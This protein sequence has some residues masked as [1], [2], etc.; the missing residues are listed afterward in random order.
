MLYRKLGD[1]GLDVSALGLGCNNF[2]VRIDETDSFKVIEQALEVGVNLFDTA[3]SYGT[4]RSEEILGKAMKGRRSQFILGTKFFFGE[5]STTLNPLWP[6]QERPNGAGGSRRHIF[7]A[8]EESLRRLGTDYIDL[9]MMHRPDPSTPIEE[10]LRALDDAV[11]QGKVR[12]IGCCAFEAW[13]LLEAIWT[14]KAMNLQQFVSAQNYYNVLRREVETEL[15]PAC[16]ATGVSLVPYFPLESGVLTGKYRLGERPPEGTRMTTAHYANRHMTEANLKKVAALQEWAQ[17]RNRS[18]G[19]LA[20]AYVLANPAVDTVISGAT[21]P[22]QV[23]E[24]VKGTA[25]Q[26]SAADLKEIDRLV[27]DNS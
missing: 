22:E 24:N 27:T 12:Y 5:G 23:V 9:Y 15:T 4:G 10:T 14:A 1:S 7:E 25:W 13:R 11:R 16:L 8:L 6:S 2:G 21:K 3:N 17:Q 26:L 18:V 19:E 20:H